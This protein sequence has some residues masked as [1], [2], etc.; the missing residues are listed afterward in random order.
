MNSPVAIDLGDSFCRVSLYKPHEGRVTIV[1]DFEGY[2]YCCYSIPSYVAFVNNARLVG[3]TAR[4]QLVR[5]PQQTISRTK[6]LLGKPFIEIEEQ[7]NNITFQV[8]PDAGNFGRPLING[9]F[10]AEEITA[11]L[12]NKMREIITHTAKQAVKDVVI[13]VPA[14]FKDAQR[15]ATIDAAE[16]AGVRVAAML[17]ETTAAAIAYALSTMEK[18]MNVLFYDFGG[19]HVSVAVASVSKCEVRILG[20][21]GNEKASGNG[22]SDRFTAS[23]AEVIVKKYKQ[24]SFLNRRAYNLLRIICERSK[25]E[26]SS[27][28]ESELTIRGVLPDLTVRIVIT[29]SQFEDACKDIFETAMEPIDEALQLAGLKID[30]IEDVVILGGS[31][32]IPK[33]DLLLREKFHKR[34]LNKR[35]HSEETVVY[36]AAMYAA[37][38]SRIVPRVIRVYDV[39]NHTIGVEQPHGVL[40]PIIPR[41]TSLPCTIRRNFTAIQGSDQSH[42]TLR[43]YEGVHAKTAE[44]TFLGSLDIVGLFPTLGDIHDVSLDFEI[45]RNGI[46]KTTQL[47]DQRLHHIKHIDIRKPCLST[48]FKHVACREFARSLTGDTQMRRLLEHRRYLEFFA[49]LLRAAIG[50]KTLDLREEEVRCLLNESEASLRWLRSNPRAQLEET[51]AKITSVQDAIAANLRCTIEEI[52]YHSLHFTEAEG[53]T[54]YLPTDSDF[55]TLNK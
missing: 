53:T 45:E 8:T 47:L 32:R 4:M 29:R 17:N 40:S 5:L 31:A 10:Y 18:T 48:D 27:N 24:D 21:A 36:G 44:N 33:I 49:Y 54:K 15:Q 38:L 12:V 22:I 2:S 19:G 39:T 34:Q 51:D 30:D 6:G 50:A 25:R 41:N 16:I 13:T 46:L 14:C 43:L 35:F 9:Q 52:V 55:D 7:L 11:V 1:P 26:L 37:Q 20:S 3:T 23:V 42:L 28:L